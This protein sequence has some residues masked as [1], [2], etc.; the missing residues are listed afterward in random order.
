MIQSAELPNTPC[1][2]NTTGLF[3]LGADLFPFGIRCTDRR[4]PSSVCTIWVSEGYPC[5]RM[6]SG[7]REIQAHYN[8]SST[9]YKQIFAI[10]WMKINVTY[11]CQVHVRIVTRHRWCKTANKNRIQKNKSV[12]CRHLNDL[13]CMAHCCFDQSEVQSRAMNHSV[14]PTFTLAEGND[15]VDLELKLFKSFKVPF[16][17]LRMSYFFFFNVK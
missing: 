16:A 6:I 2:R 4:Y 17:A 3:T 9:K 13:I 14:L 7:Y 5:R 11:R 12:H 1:W 8:T 15:R 10:T